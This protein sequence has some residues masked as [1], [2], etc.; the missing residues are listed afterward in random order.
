MALDRLSQADLRAR[1]MELHQEEAPRGWSRANLLLRLAEIEGMG[2]VHKTSKEIPPLRQAEI[3]IN[4]ASRKKALLVELMETQMNMSVTGNETIEQLKLKALNQAYACSP[5]HPQDPVGFG[6]HAAKTYEEVASQ[7][8]S[9]LEWAITT[10]KEGS[11]CPR[12]R[13][14]AE[15]A[16]TS[17]GQALMMEGK[18]GRHKGGKVPPGRQGKMATKGYVAPQPSSGTMASLVNQVETLTKELNAL[19]GQKARKTRTEGE[20]VSSSDWDKMSSAPSAA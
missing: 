1:L 20:E 8:P 19:K 2:V 7:E 3:M 12:L 14:L 6:T 10:M 13:R 9:Y 16:D 4:K 18:N 17:A 15:W 5:A 11:C